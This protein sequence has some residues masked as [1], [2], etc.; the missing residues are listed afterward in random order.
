MPTE[1]FGAKGPPPSEIEGM[2]IPLLGAVAF[3]YPFNLTGNPAAT[4]RTGLTSSGLPA[5]LQIV[6]PMYRDDLVLHLA[7][8]YEEAAPWINH[9]PDVKGFSKGKIDP[10]QVRPDMPIKSKVAL[11]VLH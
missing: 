11:D 5:G 8:D 10:H 7:K 9:W 4:V 1:P 3:T 6:G 2:P